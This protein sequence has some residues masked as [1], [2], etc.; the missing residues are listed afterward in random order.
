MNQDK[1]TVFKTDKSGEYLKRLIKAQDHT[2]AA[3]GSGGYEIV[4]KEPEKDPGV[5]VFTECDTAPARTFIVKVKEQ[6]IYAGKVA[7][8]ILRLLQKEGIRFITYQAEPPKLAPCNIF[9]KGRN[10]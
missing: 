9:K 3:I 5:F 8:F 2:F 10:D 7:D 4:E 1:I 6:R